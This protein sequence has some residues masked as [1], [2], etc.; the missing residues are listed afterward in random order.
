MAGTTIKELYAAV[1]KAKDTLAA[2]SL[3]LGSS[4]DQPITE[5]ADDA[6]LRLE[7][8]YRKWS[9][10]VDRANDLFYYKVGDREQKPELEA[11]TGP[12][13]TDTERRRREDPGFRAPEPEE[14]H[15]PKTDTELDA[16]L[17]A[18]GVDSPAEPES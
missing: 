12:K 5:M 11:T 16:D 4:V 6:R 10:E 17:E 15:P 18:D 7:Q 2:L 9:D 3:E 13:E 8:L 1:R 14:T